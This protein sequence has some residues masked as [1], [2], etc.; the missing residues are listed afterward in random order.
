MATDSPGTERFL[1]LATRPLGDNA[2]LHLAVRHDLAQKIEASSAATQAVLEEAADRL[3]AA[4]RRPSRRWLRLALVVVAVIAVLVPVVMTTVGILRQRTFYARLI[5]PFSAVSDKGEDE[6][7][8]PWVT[9][10]KVR[11]LLLGD[12]AASDGAERWRPLWQSDPMNR[13]YF[14]KYILEYRAAHEGISDALLAE[15]EKIDPDNGWYLAM[16]ASAKLGA[17]VM[18]QEKQSRADLKAGKPRTWRVID[19]AAY[20]LARDQF[21]RAV[22]KRDF[23]NHVNELRRE[24][25]A[26][27]PP[28]HDFS[29]QISLYRW[30]SEDTSDVVPMLRVSR[31]ISHEANRCVAENDAN[32]FR[33]VFQAWK[34]WIHYSIQDDGTLLSVVVAKSAVESSLQS[35]RVGAEYFGMIDEAEALRKMEGDFA[36][37]KARRE[38]MKSKVSDEVVTIEKHASMISGVALPMLMGVLKSPPRFTEEELKPGRLV[39][40]ALFGQI[41]MRAFALLLLLAAGAV[42]LVRFRH[43]VYGRRLSQRLC[44][45]LRASDG[46]AMVVCGVVLPCAWFYLL[47]CCTPL[48]YKDWSV[49]YTTGVMVAGQWG[50]LVI[51]MLT[52]SVSAVAWRLDKRLRFLGRTPKTAWFGWGVTLCAMLSIPLFGMFPWLP[53]PFTEYAQWFGGAIGG[54]VALWLFSGLFSWVTGFPGEGAVRRVAI[55]RLLVPVWLIGAVLCS[56]LSYAHIVEERYWFKRETLNRSSWEVQGYTQYEGKVARQFRKELAEVIGRLP[57]L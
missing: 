44:A 13:V 26:H 35:L 10:P 47:T 31:L 15:A 21:Y 6:R 36:A 48:S 37:D 43:G 56:A 19:E 55:T 11:L 46:W 12:E 18:T 1:E 39:E 53:A 4:D 28:P 20:R 50:G 27:L 29:S 5:D 38:V 32:G 57:S 17:K 30:M 9:D 24:Q 3:D 51:L 8:F 33:Q 14:A 16:S 40:Y 22:A 23:M 45:L 7:V 25:L 34:R 41:S 2:E 49:R 52:A 54:V 42:A